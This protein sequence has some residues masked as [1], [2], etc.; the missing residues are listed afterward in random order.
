MPAVSK[1]QQA[2]F[3]MALCYKRGECEDVPDEAKKLAKQMSEKSLRDFAKT[4][5]KG[6]PKHVK[7]S[8]IYNTRKVDPGKLRLFIDWLD[9]K[10]LTYI[11]KVK[12]HEIEIFNE[13]DLSKEDEKE[14]LTYIN[15]LQLEKVWENSIAT[16]GNTI[17]MGYI[18]PPQP[19]MYSN[20]QP[21][22]EF[23][24]G[25]GDRFDNGS[26]KEDDEKIEKEKKKLKR[27]KKQMKKEEQIKNK[28][29]K[30]EEFDF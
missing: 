28:T 25:S 12:E 3:G 30:F 5:H 21:S 10:N 17:G 29:L 24:I 27:L 1:A 14:F 13:Y 26:A 15:R 8:I 20:G 23:G 9:S 2:L 4:P 7:E 22:I 19:S 6:L 11:N 18:N 16:L